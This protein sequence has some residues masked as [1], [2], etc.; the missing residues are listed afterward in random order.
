MYDYFYQSWHEGG[1]VEWSNTFDCKAE[2]WGSNS[3]LI[4]CH[5]GSSSVYTAGCCQEGHPNVIP[6]I[7]PSKNPW[8]V[9]SGH[10]KTADPS[11]MRIRQYK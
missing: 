7:A 10:G 8:P 6:Q 3:G 4:C 11:R 2:V 1:V 5:Q 9:N